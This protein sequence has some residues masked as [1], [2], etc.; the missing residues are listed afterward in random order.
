MS[1]VTPTLPPATHAAGDAFV[2]SIGVESICDANCATCFGNQDTQCNTCYPGWFGAGRPGQ[3][4]ECIT[5]DDV[6]AS[7]RCCV[8]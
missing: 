3:D 1:G 6:S 8:V 2:I 5:G 7:T 4:F